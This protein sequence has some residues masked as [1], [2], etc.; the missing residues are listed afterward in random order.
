MVALLRLRA[1]ENFSPVMTSEYQTRQ[2]NQERQTEEEVDAVFSN[3]VLI[4]AKAKTTL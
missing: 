3:F 4:D 2:W 1:I